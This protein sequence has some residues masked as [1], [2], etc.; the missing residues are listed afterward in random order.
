MKKGILYLEDVYDFSPYK[1]GLDIIC[2][3][4]LGNVK[5]GKKNMK[6]KINLGKI[7]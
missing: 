2:A 7:Y 1:G 4:L 6:W 3:P 5:D